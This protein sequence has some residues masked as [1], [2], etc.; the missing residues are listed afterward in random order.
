M[1]SGGMGMGRGGMGQGRAAGAGAGSEDDGYSMGS[2][3]ALNVPMY[4]PERASFASPGGSMGEGTGA[5]GRPTAVRSEAV[6]ERG[7]GTPPEAAAGRG[8]PSIEQMPEKYREAIKRYFSEGANA[9]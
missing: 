3:S 2:Q 8:S 1:M 7:A 5:Q 6:G 4:G 9:P